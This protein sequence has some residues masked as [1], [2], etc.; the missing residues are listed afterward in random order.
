MSMT[1]LLTDDDPGFRESVRQILVLEDY[2]VLEAKDGV[3]ALRLLKSEE[4]GLLITDILM[5]DME[6]VELCT[7][8][9]ALRPDLKVI[10]MTGGGS[11]N[12]D[13]VTGIAERF[14]HAFLKKPFDRQDLLDK[15]KTF[16]SPVGRE[17]VSSGR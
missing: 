8:A 5:P 12:A 17:S 14:F 6:G 1:I 2:R 15:V 16:E 3:E 11:I 13:S 7:K 4:V 9:K 10:G